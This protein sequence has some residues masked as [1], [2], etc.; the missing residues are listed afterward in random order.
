LLGHG[1][2]RNQ[3]A[4]SR[5]M[6]EALIAASLSLL[7]NPQYLFTPRVLDKNRSGLACRLENYREAQLLRCDKAHS[8]LR[9]RNNIWISRSF[10]MLKYNNMISKQTKKNNNNKTTN[11]LL[12][13]SQLMGFKDLQTNGLYRH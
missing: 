2:G 4:P 6:Q 7:T 12:I 9:R 11:Q 13:V 8:V 3:K 5:G 1:L 10:T